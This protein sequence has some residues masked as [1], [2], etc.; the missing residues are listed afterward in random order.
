M[1]N[2]E[3]KKFNQIMKQNFFPQKITNEHNSSMI[4]QNNI[5]KAELFN[6]DTNHKIENIKNLQNKKKEEQ[7]KNQNKEKIKNDINKKRKN[8]EKKKE[9]M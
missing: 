5:S 1:Y 6:F 2:N 7:K 3:V 9:K 4:S 8:K